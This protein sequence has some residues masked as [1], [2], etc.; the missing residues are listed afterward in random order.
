MVTVL[1]HTDPTIE[2]A[3]EEIQSDPKKQVTQA[4][5]ANHNHQQ[6]LDKITE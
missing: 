5:Q 6:Q 1:N 4:V 2:L 3:A